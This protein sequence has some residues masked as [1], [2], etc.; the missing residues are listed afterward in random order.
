MEAIDNQPA[1]LSQL[2]VGLLDGL[3]AVSIEYGYVSEMIRGL[4]D[5]IVQ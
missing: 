1:A 2:V 5:L 4:H 3:H